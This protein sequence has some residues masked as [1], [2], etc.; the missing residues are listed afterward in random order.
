MDNHQRISIYNPALTAVVIGY[1]TLYRY[2]NLP[3]FPF[4]SIPSTTT[5]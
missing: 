3:I 4:S 5:L 2:T 1:S